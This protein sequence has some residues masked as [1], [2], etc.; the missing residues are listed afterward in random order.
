MTDTFPTIH[1]MHG[2]MGSGKTTLAKRLEIDLPAVRLTHDEIMVSRYGR[3]PSDYDEKYKQVDDDIKAQAAACIKKG[4]NVILDYGFWTK[5]DR[6]AYY[7]WAKSLTPHVL[8][9]VIKCDKETAKS[10]VLKRTEENSA[11]LLIDEACFENLYK[12]FEPLTQEEGYPIEFH[13]S[14]IRRSARAILIDRERKLVLMKRDRRFEPTYYVTI[15][16]GIEQ[17]ETSEAAV[18]REIQEET[19]FIVDEPQFLFHFNDPERP[20]SVDFFLCSEV[21]RGVP[22]GPELKNEIPG[23]HYE[24]VSV[25]LEEV[26]DLNLKPDCLKEQLID[27][28]KKALNK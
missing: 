3:H 9:H 18:R 28:Y 15:G 21:K 13:E 2:F 23:N 11:E 6:K 5:K 19:G 10:R 8:F 7:A 22:T 4:Q 16:G 24:L 25:T 20:N 26:I 12:K 1:L 27:F 17:G 14:A